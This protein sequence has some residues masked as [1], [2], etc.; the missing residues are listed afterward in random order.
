M[1]EL[2]VKTHFAAAHQL[3]MVQSK[4]ENLHG[5]NWVIHVCVYGD[6]LDEAGLLIDFSEIKTFVNDIIE[7][8]DHNF[9]NEMPFFQ[10]HNPS[11]ENIARYIAE[12]LSK[13][14]QSSRVRV[15]SVTAWESEDASATYFL[16]QT[17]K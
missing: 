1:Y 14:F 11:S 2:N 17:D 15:K 3:R 16:P 12:Q 6:Q 13:M 7:E 8:L 5:H 10:T 9:L 4:C